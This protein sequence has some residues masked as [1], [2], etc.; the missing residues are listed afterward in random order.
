MK[1]CENMKGKNAN[2]EAGIDYQT[3]LKT[4]RHNVEA[5]KNINN[6]TKKIKEKRSARSQRS[7]LAADAT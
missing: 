5:R 7:K 3:Q 6:Q 2:T 1:N 4:A